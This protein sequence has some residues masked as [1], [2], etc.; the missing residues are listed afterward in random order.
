VDEASASIRR[1]RD[2]LANELDSLRRLIVNLRPPV[3][4]DEGIAGALADCAARV[5]HGD[6]ASHVESTLESPL[7]PQLETALYRIAREALLNVD[8]HARA[9]RVDVTLF[10]RDDEIVLSI[11]DDGRGFD[12]S[13]YARNADGYPGL[14]SMDDLAQSLGGTLRV[15]SGRGAGT[16][17]RAVMPRLEPADY[18]ST[19]SQVTSAG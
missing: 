19:L 5:L 15:T 1:I 12:G 7:A 3:L 4:N 17:G 18:G 13:A 10:A 11:R 16:E 6:I 14:R 9:R 8:T 2:E